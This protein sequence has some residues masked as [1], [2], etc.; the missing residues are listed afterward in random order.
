M[1]DTVLRNTVAPSLPF[2]TEE[3]QEQYI[4][5]L[6][7]ILRLYFNTIDGFNS[8]LSAVNG[9]RELSFPHVSA[10]DTTDQYASATNTPTIVKWNT[11]DSASG[12]TLEPG[13]YAI[14]LQQGLFNIQYSLQFINTSNAS[15]DV[16]V[17]LRVNNIDVPGSA[18]KFTVPSRKSVGN[19]GYVVAVS[20]IPFRM[21]PDDEVALWW[22]TSLAYNPVG[23]VDGVYMEYE[24]A[25]TSPFAHPSV[26]SALGAITFINR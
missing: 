12:F 18:S 24:A 11:L 14:A 16:T 3:Y 15:E 4:N 13:N 5:Q 23:P 9:G 25:Q 20:V 19:N 17:W 26:P 2:A 22:A 21:N 7:N 6:N 8:A 10:Y 1:S